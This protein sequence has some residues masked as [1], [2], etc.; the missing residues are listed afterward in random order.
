MARNRTARRRRYRLDG[1]T[2]VVGALLV[3]LAVDYLRAHPALVTKLLLAVTLAVVVW[4]AVLHYR[5][6]VSPMRLGPDAFEHYVAGLLA[7]SGMRGVRVSGGA[8][9]LGADVTARDPRG[10]WVVAQC[11]RYGR[12]NPVGSEDM[13]RFVGTARP[14][15]EADI[16]LLVT[17]SHFTRPALAY[18]EQHDVI[19]VDGAALRRWRRTGRMPWAS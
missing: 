13:Q 10:Q 5:F 3:W 17:T 2:L 12:Q 19:T 15:H 8:G 9:D 7:R 18:A 11:K 4:V 14:H 16:A 6:T 1:P